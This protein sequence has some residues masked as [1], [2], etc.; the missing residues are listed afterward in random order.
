MTGPTKNLS[1][2]E[3]ACKDGTPYPYE[4]RKTRAIELGEL[5]EYIRALCG[6]RAIKVVSA[7]RT[8]S[9]NKTVGGVA[10]S[11]HLFGRALDL[12]PPE[13]VSMNRFYHIIADTPMSMALK[14]L[15]RYDNFIH[16]DTR[17][18]SKRALWDFR[19]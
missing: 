4:W 16:I 7:Y 6:G 8:V 18:T 2:K 11:Q 9:Y 15:G 1:W 3:L 17:P 10:N 14:G 12:Q 5:F 13:G 19:S